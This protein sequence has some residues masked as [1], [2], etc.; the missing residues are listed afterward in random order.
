MNS[1]KHPHFVQVKIY[2]E[3]EINCLAL[4]TAFSFFEAVAVLRM[5]G[6]YFV[7]HVEVQRLE[8]WI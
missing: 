2:K 6:F 5:T 3:M 1:P 4:S 8:G 7:W